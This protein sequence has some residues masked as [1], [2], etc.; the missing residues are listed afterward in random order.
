M[1]D[2]PFA[3][4]DSSNCKIDSDKILLDITSVAMAKYEK[5]V[6][7]NVQK[8]PE[9]DL[10][11]L[12]KPPMSLPTQNI[13]AYMA[14]YLHIW[15]GNYHPIIAMNVLSNLYYHSYY[16]LIKNCLYELLRNKTYQESG[17]LMYPTE[18]M[19]RFV[20]QIEQIFYATFEDIIYMSFILERL[21]KSADEESQFLTCKEVE[22]TL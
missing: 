11:M 20:E 3:Q 21:C 15:R 8:L 2:K 4:S 18:R 19:V 13:A 9:M 10:A 7:T 22:C 5:Q 12:I 1:A 16:L 6:P 14:G 17:C